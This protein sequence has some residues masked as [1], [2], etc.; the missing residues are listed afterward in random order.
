M[1]ERAGREKLGRQR[2]ESTLGHTGCTK[3]P[4]PL[5]R[6]LCMALHLTCESK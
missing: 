3:P 2:Q 4:L 6:E 1:G 5:T